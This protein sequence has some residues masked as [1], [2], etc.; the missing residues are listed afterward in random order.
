M[1]AQERSCGRTALHFATETDNVSLAG[2]LLLEVGS[3]GS[4]LSKFHSSD[5]EPNL[6]CACMC[7]VFCHQGNAKVDSCTFNGSTP[8]HIAAGRSSVKLTALLMAAGRRLTCTLRCS[9]M[10]GGGFYQETPAVMRRN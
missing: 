10:S 9:G 8:L 2:C 5:T 7:D 6:M 1:E 3:P 4:A